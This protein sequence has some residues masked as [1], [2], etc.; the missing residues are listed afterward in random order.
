MHS[1]IFEISLIHSSN[2]SIAPSCWNLNECLIV[3][4]IQTARC[5]S[6]STDDHTTLRQEELELG[7]IFYD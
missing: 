1:E 5:S 7:A 3:D 6:L 2:Y 4:V